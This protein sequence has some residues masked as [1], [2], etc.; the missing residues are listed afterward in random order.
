MCNVPPILLLLEVY[1][2][3]WQSSKNQFGSLISENRDIS[4][5]FYWTQT[6]TWWIISIKAGLI[7]QATNP[8]RNL[9]PQLF[10]SNLK[11]CQN[12]E[13][14]SRGIQNDRIDLSCE[15]ADHWTNK[16]HKC[17]VEKV[18]NCGN[19]Q[20]MRGLPQRPVEKVW[21]TCFSTEGKML[22]KLGL[23]PLWHVLKLHRRNAISTFQLWCG[24]HLTWHDSW[25]TSLI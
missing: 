16:G 1:C 15:M 7:C 8:H 21:L 10:V 23:W 11:A 14:V 20:Y 25:H 12:M 2:Y 17:S 3:R 19:F 5:P 18:L 4:L 24:F 6:P 22:R 13:Y 9:L